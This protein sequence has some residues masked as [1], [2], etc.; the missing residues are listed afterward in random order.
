MGMVFEIGRIIA[1]EPGRLLAFTWRRASFAPDQITRVEVR[2]EPMGAE[3]R[4]TVEHRGWDTV[5]QEHVARAPRLS[6]FGVPA[7]ARGMVAGSAG[8][9]SNSQRQR[10][11][12]A[13]FRGCGMGSGI[14]RGRELNKFQPDGWSTVTPR[15][16]TLDVAALAEFLSSVFD[17]QGTLRTDGPTEMRIGDSIVMISNGGGVRQATSAFLYVY[18]ENIDKAY[19][20]AIAVG[21]RSIE[22]PTDMPYG[23]RR[24]TIQDRWGN[25]WQIA[26]YKGM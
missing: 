10:H 11:G 23:D 13:I 4:V 24:A 1:W 7:A 19:N 2:F 9:L 15:L 5:P 22:E 3:T 25:I 17:A 12:G 26:T 20:R 6:R 18:V 21:A 8:V 14:G 16:F